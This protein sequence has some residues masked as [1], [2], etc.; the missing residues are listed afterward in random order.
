[1]LAPVAEADA[2]EPA[3]L[4]LGLRSAA[5]WPAFAAELGVALHTAGSTARSATTVV[6]AAGAWSGTLADVA[7]R[8]VKGQTV[9]LCPRAGEPAPLTHTVRFDGGYLVPRADGRIVLGATMEERG[10]DT[11]MTAGAVHE[12]L[13]DAAELVPGVL[14]LEIE[15]LTAGL[16]PCTP[17]NVPIVRRLDERVIAATGHGRNGILLAPLT[18]E[19]V[20]EQLAAVAA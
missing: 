7:V 16:R 1:M 12:L 11:A 9:R 5:A 15:E 8:P 2:R 3:L 17:D 6:L 20:V 13:R 14:E 10:F 4:D 19:L 18:A